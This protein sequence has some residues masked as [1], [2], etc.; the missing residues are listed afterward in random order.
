MAPSHSKRARSESS[1]SSVSNFEPESSSN[2]ES[3]SVWPPPAKIRTKTKRVPVSKEETAALGKGIRPM[4]NFRGCDCK[5]Q[6]I[7]TLKRIK[8]AENQFGFAVY[9]TKQHTTHTHP[10]NGDAW[11]AY[12]ENR[13]VED[14]EI[15]EMV[16]KF[17]AVDSKFGKIHRYVIDST[18]V[19]ADQKYARKIDFKDKQREKRK[20]EVQP[21]TEG[22]AEDGVEDI[23]PF[24]KHAEYDE[25]MNRLLNKTTDHAAELVFPGYAYATKLYAALEAFLGIIEASGVPLISEAPWT[26]RKDSNCSDTGIQK[27]GSDEDERVP[28]TQP[29]KPDESRQKPVAVRVD[30]PVTAPTDTIP[31]PEGPTEEPTATLISAPFKLNRKVKVSGR[32]KTTKA[33]R[34]WYPKQAKPS[35]SKIIS[36]EYESS[37]ES[38]NCMTFEQYKPGPMSFEL[39]CDAPYELFTYNDKRIDLSSESGLVVKFHPSLDE[40]ATLYSESIIDTMARFHEKRNFLKNVDACLKWIVAQAQRRSVAVD[41]VDEITSALREASVYALIKIRDEEVCFVYELLAFR[42]K[43]W[44][45]DMC[46]RLAIQVMTQDRSDIVYVDGAMFEH[47]Q[48]QEIHLNERLCD[49]FD[50][51][52]DYTIKKADNIRQEDG[53]N[54]GIIVIYYMESYIS[55]RIVTNPNQVLLQSIRLAYFVQGLR[56]LYPDKDLRFFG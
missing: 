3:S 8:V 39:V 42:S 12:A 18:V 10:L 11:R 25:E 13:R 45:N 44:L 53:H 41:R 7:A 54:C 52:S 6:I 29:T 40:N 26:Q 5:A 15:I 28:E 36:L 51:Q 22:V 32:P 14:P 50:R 1:S 24:V 23:H 31:A 20:K 9:V 4:Q 19:Q 27:C 2:D 49:V 47:I 46:I 34:A 35:T 30:E 38:D 16:R 37:E 56:R 43:E 48:P 21:D 55:T 33:T 17:V